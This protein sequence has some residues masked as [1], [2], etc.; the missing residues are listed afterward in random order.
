MDMASF[1]LAYFRATIGK[2]DCEDGA[3]L[4]HSLLLHA[5]VPYDRIGTYGGLVE[6]GEGAATGGHAWTAYRRESDD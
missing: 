2:G 1:G 4:V 5:G 6:S 3:F